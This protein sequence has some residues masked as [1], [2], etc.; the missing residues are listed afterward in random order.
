MHEV[1]ALKEETC[2]R[3]SQVPNYT[4]AQ[5]NGFEVWKL[6]EN[7]VTNVFLSSFLIF[8]MTFSR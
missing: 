6:R 3:E 1:A 8:Y 5:K 2:S 4:M 7:S